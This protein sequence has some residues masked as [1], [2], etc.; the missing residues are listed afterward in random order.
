M[1][2]QCGPNREASKTAEIRA[3]RRGATRAGRGEHEDTARALH[4]VARGGRERV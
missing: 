4:Y 3:F 1:H 2:F